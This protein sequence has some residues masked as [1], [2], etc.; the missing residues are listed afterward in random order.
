MPE[1]R[2]DPIA[3]RWVVVNVEK[4]YLPEDFKQT[5]FVWK[6]DKDCPFCYGKEAVTPVEIEAFSDNWRAPNT[7]GWKVRAVPNKF[8]A[9]RIEGDLDK[10]ALGLYDVSNGVGAHEVIV[11]SPHHFKGMT[12]LE[13]V[14]VEYI[15]RMYRS[16]ALDLR[17][18]KRFKYLLIFKNV[19]VDAG[20][21]MEH[22]HSQL[23]ALPMVPK[24]VNEEIKGAR[25]HY[26]YRERC[27]FC[28]ILAYEE[29]NEKERIVIENDYFVA[30]CPLSSRFSFEI[31]IMPKQHV[32]DFGEISDNDL[33]P[34]AKILKESLT[35]LKKVLGEHSYNYI[36]HTSPVNTEAHSYYHWHIEIMPKLSRVAGFEWGSG[37]YVVS[38]PPELAAK[39][40][41]EAK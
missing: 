21:S 29:E 10:H 1:F 39:Y 2:K 40:L 41:R 12:D 19:G 20:A 18:D 38:T 6:G 17:K 32:M 5:S 23:I 33:N 3:G 4:P 15:L 28:D 8:P 26:E 22:G 9:L 24:N 31:W 36:I 30:F 11:D 16:R 7:P 35:R 13:D 14:E 25:H 34:L 37:F 27:V